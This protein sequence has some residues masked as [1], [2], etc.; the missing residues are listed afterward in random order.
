MSLC[1]PK[2]H[3]RIKENMQTRDLGNQSTSLPV[4]NNGKVFQHLIKKKSKV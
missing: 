3:Q 2:Q 1:W 4:K